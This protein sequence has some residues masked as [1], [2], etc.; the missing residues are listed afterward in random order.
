MLLN[1]QLMSEIIGEKVMADEIKDIASEETNEESN[2]SSEEENKPSEEEVLKEDKSLLE[3]DDKGTE[4]TDGKADE[5]KGAPETYDDFVVPD[6]MEINS[7]TL[8][9]TVSIFKEANLTQ[10]IAQNLIELH[11]NQVKKEAEAQIESWK[12]TMNE[13]KE[14]SKNDKEFGGNAFNESLVTAKEAV[15]AFGNEKF[16]EMLETSGLANHPEMIRF[17]YTIGKLTKEHNILH[18]EAKGDMKPSPE[19]L[20]YPTMMK[21]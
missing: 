10:E 16:S 5:V 8:E 21:G 20:M 17:L 9:E 6:G 15:K 18:G 2:N 13:W 1:I 11:S 7:E 12:T 19:E 14:L 3:D 4:D